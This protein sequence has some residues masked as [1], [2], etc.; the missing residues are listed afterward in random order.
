MLRP[1]F[2]SKSGAAVLIGPLAGSTA[3]IRT[4][5]RIG[6]TRPQTGL[7]EDTAFPVPWR[8]PIKC[9]TNVFNDLAL[10]HPKPARRYLLR[11]ARTRLPIGP[12]AMRSAWN[13]LTGECMVA[14][15]R[16]RG[17]YRE[18]GNNSRGAGFAANISTWKYEVS[19]F[20]RAET[21]R[22]WLQEHGPSRAVMG[23][24]CRAPR[25]H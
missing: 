17:R 3:A 16:L 10:A 6:R 5:A 4:R 25:R 24:S 23:L 21:S 18:C 11:A 19:N 7:F 9:Q 13:P 8:C 20:L 22:D 2:L 12:Y 1:C 14:L 15:K